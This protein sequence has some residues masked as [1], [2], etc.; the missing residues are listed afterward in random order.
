MDPLKLGLFGIGQGD[1][2]AATGLKERMEGNLERVQRTLEQ[3]RIV[4]VNLGLNGLL[5]PEPVESRS[6]RSSRNP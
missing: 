2:A 3:P 1:L 5:R 4:I 6:T